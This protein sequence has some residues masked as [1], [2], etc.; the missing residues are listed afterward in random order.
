MSVKNQLEDLLLRKKSFKLFMSIPVNGSK[1]VSMLSKEAD[2]TYSHTIKILNELN[3]L[4]LITFEKT[5]RI[6]F[7]MLT[8]DGK[9]I[10]KI[11]QTL[12]RKFSSLKK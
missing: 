4:G 3:A 2:C 10:S 8:D 11:F 12:L 9:D 6:K 5:G 7:V 1:Y